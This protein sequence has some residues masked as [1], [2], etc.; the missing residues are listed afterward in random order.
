MKGTSAVQSALD[1]LDS[2]EID[3]SSWISKM[4]EK[5]KSKLNAEPTELDLGELAS[6]DELN[7]LL[8]RLRH[9]GETLGC[10]RPGEQSKDEIIREPLESAHNTSLLVHVSNSNA[11]SNEAFTAWPAD[12]DGW[13][14]YH[15]RLLLEEADS[16]K[17]SLVEESC[18]SE[19]EPSHVL[20]LSHFCCRGHSDCPSGKYCP[21]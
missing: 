19:A 5:L 13:R 3:I 9:L 20:V 17:L 12:S 21:I 2:F 14:R 6:S 15:C 1:N 18:K 7:S 16:P 8:R 11:P 4:R 10:C